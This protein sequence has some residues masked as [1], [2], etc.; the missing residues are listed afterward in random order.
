MLELKLPR[1]AAAVVAI[2]TV[3]A[4]TQ[5]RP[6]MT[7]GRSG[8]L[9]AGEAPA[10]TATIPPLVEAAPYVP[11]PEPVPESERY[12]VVVND[13]PVRELLFALARDA[14]LN[15]D[16]DSA[17]SGRVTLNAIDQTLPQILERIARQVAL[18]YEFTG[19]TVVIGPDEPYLRTYDVGYVNL[20]R[21]VDTTVNVAT[22]V[23]TTGGGSVD[24]TGGGSGGGRGGGDNTSSTRLE[25][26]SYNRFW[27]T[28][29][30]NILAILGQVERRSTR[31]SD[32]VIINAEAG[33]VSVRATAGQHQQIEDF[34][35]R[36]LVN[37]R[38][39]VMIEATIVEVSLN[40]QYQAGV[41]WTVFLQQG[42]SG[43]TVDQNLLGQIT[44]GAIDN[45]VSSF[46]LGYFQPDVGNNAVAASVR[47]L[48]EFGDAKV[49]SSPRL[50]V[51][52]NQTA[53]LKVVEELVYFTIEVTDR[54]ATN[55][56]QGRIVVESEVNSVPVGLVMAV[57]PQISANNEI[58]LTVRPTISQK[59]GDAVDPGPQIALQFIDTT[60]AN[61]TNT[62]PIIRVRE[63]ESVLKLID[64]QIGV[65]GGLMQDEVRQ[66]NREVPGLAQVP[67]IG[68]LFFNTDEAVSS[69]SEL[70][71]FLRPVVV[72][73]PSIDTDLNGYRRFLG[74]ATGATTAPAP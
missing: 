18:R 24:D 71:I 64:G 54:D 46:T 50:M 19:D 69:K 45:A 15:I 70:V 26:R 28:L 30:S 44:D 63:M 62:V 27:E 74:G 25:S 12:T 51:L 36:V 29:E 41:D 33:M 21:D 43:F 20:S 59:I 8:H 35:D 34:I 22:R 3:A 2:A 56:Q 10:A 4:C 14:E 47:L 61:I 60:A 53:I 1:L 73:D 37:V 11:P 6:E 65:L 67:L 57:T 31:G 9:D 13:V 7:P 17:V 40:D 39:Q 42:E 55:N 38:R 58:T 49:L 72:R 68:D 23:A 52:N 66:G 5:M 32:S 48:R 16:I